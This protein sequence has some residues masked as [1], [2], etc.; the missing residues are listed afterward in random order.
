MT[1]GS[2]WMHGEFE[3]NEDIIVPVATFVV[4]D[5]AGNCLYLRN[6]YEQHSIG[7]IERWDDMPK[8]SW[9]TY[10]RIV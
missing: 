10:K 3:I 8:S 9:D 7:R 1:P 4:L 6:D 2:V 5:E